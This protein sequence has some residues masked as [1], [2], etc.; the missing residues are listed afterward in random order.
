[1]K[2]NKAMTAV[3]GIIIA[4]IL[5]LNYFYQV[6]GFDFTLKCV[7]SVSFAS[8]G[9]INLCHALI[10]RQANKR[11]YI[12]TTAGLIF[13]MLGD[14]LIGYDFIVG[15]LMFAMG[16]VCFI[17]AY[18]FLRKMGKSDLIF[19]GILFLFALAF[20]LFCP[21]LTFSNP[22][23]RTVCIAYALIISLMLGKAAGNLAKNKCIFT[24]IIA[25]ASALFFFSDLMLVFERFAGGWLWAGRV[26]M[27]TYYPALC[28]LAFSMY[29]KTVT[30]EKTDFERNKAE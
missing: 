23:F 21:L 22:V 28:L 9:V 19:S 13:A 8:L 7:C 5:V 30:S 25:L 1:M 15:A 17:F 12:G 26:C 4:V 20:L 29:H 14:V 27:A 2:H 6:K 11:F 18:C 24:G 3:N 10:A 16:H